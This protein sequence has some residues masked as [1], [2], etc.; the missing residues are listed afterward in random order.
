MIFQFVRDN[1]SCDIRDGFKKKAENQKKFLS[2]TESD[3]EIVE[4]FLNYNSLQISYRKFSTAIWKKWKLS[5]KMIFR[6]G[7]FSSTIAINVEQLKSI[8]SFN[9]LHF[10][11]R[12][13]MIDAL[14]NEEKVFWFKFCHF[15]LRNRRKSL[16][17]FRKM[18]FCSS[19][20]FGTGWE[21]TK[22]SF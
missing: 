2:A 14:L 13:K 21:K 8:L 6:T 19:H 4:K 11:L 17:K 5:L 15:S 9:K 3:C 16:W 12:S 10:Q 20:C 22:K 18:S 7:I 1:R